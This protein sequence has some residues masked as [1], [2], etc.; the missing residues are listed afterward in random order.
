MS[1]WLVSQNHLNVLV[2]YALREG[3]IG[4]N[5]GEKTFKVLLDE[6]IRSLR[7]RYSDTKDWENSAATYHYTDLLL[8]RAYDWAM[9]AVVAR[10]AK[11][12]KSFPASPVYKREAP[13][14]SLKNFSTFIHK[15]CDCYDY[16]ACENLDYDTTEASIIITL[17]REA[18]IRHGGTDK[19]KVYDFMPWGID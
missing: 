7:Y 16:Q 14:R 13:R 5:D 12:A 19:G 6:N 10:N 11:L 3:C 1:A 2:A 17:I 15:A 9:D 8:D 18:A 4:A